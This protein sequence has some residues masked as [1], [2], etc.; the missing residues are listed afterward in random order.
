M[1][2][3]DPARDQFPQ[4]EQDMG[5]HTTAPVE[6]GEAVRPRIPPQRNAGLY[7]CVAIIL[8]CIV[9]WVGSWIAALVL[10]ILACLVAIAGLVFGFHHV[11][12]VTL[13]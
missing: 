4:G 3:F 6:I 10:T 12:K 1:S 7:A 2:D 9:H 8:L 11:I 5:V 13:H